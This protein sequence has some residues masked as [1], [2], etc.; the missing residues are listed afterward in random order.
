MNIC[1]ALGAHRIIMFESNVIS[2]E[3]LYHF[4]SGKLIK[5]IITCYDIPFRKIV[6]NYFK[7]K[8]LP[9]YLSTLQKKHKT[10]IRICKM[11]MQNIKI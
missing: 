2:L 8:R 3:N 10:S 6:E 9:R 7:L 11:Y 5:S 4:E 1:C